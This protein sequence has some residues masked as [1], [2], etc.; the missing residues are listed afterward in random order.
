MTVAHLAPHVAL[1]AAL[2][3]ATVLV[4]REGHRGHTRPG[5]GRPRAQPREMKRPLPF[6]LH[7]EA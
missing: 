4:L 3:V 1:L 7:R 2:T 6:E 5:H